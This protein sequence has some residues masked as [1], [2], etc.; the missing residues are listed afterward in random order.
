MSASRLVSSPALRSATMVDRLRAQAQETPDRVAYV[1][2]RDGEVEEA[3]LTCAALDARARAIGAWLQVEAQPGD[4]ALLLYPPGLEFVAAF[5]GCLYAG[6]AAVP[7]YPPRVNRPD[8]R[9]QEIAADSRPKVV[10]T[11]EPVRAALAARPEVVAGL[12]SARWLAT[13]TLA[14]DLGLRWR[15]P[16]VEPD[17]LALLQYTSGSTFTPK[18]VMVTHGNI[19]ANQVSIDRAIHQ[20]RESVSV[21]WLPHFHDMGLI[22]GV[23]HP[24]YKG[25]LGVLMA[26][27]AFLQRPLR[28]LQAMSRYGGTL[29]G[30]PNFA[31]ELCTARLSSEEKATLDLSRWEVAF[32]G[33]EPIRASTLQEFARAFAPCGLRAGALG[34]AYG[35]A[36]ATLMVTVGEK[37][38]GPVVLRARGAD[39]ERNRFAPAPADEPDARE[40]VGCGPPA[41]S[42]RVRIVDPQTG[43]PCPPD[44]IGEIWVAGPS[45]A[46]GYFGRPEETARTFGAVLPGEPGTF[47]RTGDL[48]FV[49][50][51]QL[52]VTGRLKDLIIIRGLNHY[53]QDIE[54]TVEG[55]HPALR[56]AAG[57]AFSV[58]AEGEEQLVVV[59]EVER[60]QRHG[61]LDEVVAAIRR[62]VV[63]AHELEPYAVALIRPAS[64]LKTS[65]GKIQRRACRTA[66][67]EGRLALLHEW[68]RPARSAAA[69]TAP[70]AGAPRTEEEITAW[71]AARLARESGLD[72]DEL[73][74]EQ[75]FAS[76]GLDSAR[77]LLLV[78]DLEGWLGRRLSPVVLW[79]Y[80]TVQA[81][82]RHLGS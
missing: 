59:H 76:F 77:A 12:A 54:N 52:Y 4:R 61:E 23:I 33:A 5:F 63:D 51:G 55:S 24:L 78:G 10:L 49:H 31:Y 6:V 47:L 80:P 8:P 2:L 1:F 30:G 36:E 7:A 16:V 67:L 41:A 60:S 15:E 44:V 70:A 75:P 13:E 17:T 37:G 40:L 81:L 66:F 3:A 32:N 68:R 72:G 82:A 34:G 22:Y 57:A 35:M 26:P 20:T 27:A 19:L 62:A 11:T 42:T 14:A 79:N 45:V 9:I 38:A 25:F 58:E 71:L 50:G 53:P 48:G 18:G 56:P 43:Q 64:M 69:D 29:S 73:D 46:K 28:W 39:L 65:S 74:L 21:S